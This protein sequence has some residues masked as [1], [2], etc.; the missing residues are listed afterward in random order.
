MSF[1]TS[2]HQS[3]ELFKTTDY[4]II[5]ATKA[6]SPEVG[7]EQLHFRRRNGDVYFK[8]SVENFLKDLGPGKPIYGI[9]GKISLAT[10]DV[11]I[12]VSSVSEPQT[13]LSAQ[14]YN[15]QSFEILPLTPHDLSDPRDRY[16][17]SLIETGLAAC[18]GRLW[19]SYERD[20]TNTVERTFRKEHQG[21]KG[22]HAFWESTEERFF[23]N[24]AM[25]KDFIKHP[26]ANLGRFILPV[27]FG[28]V[29]VKSARVN[30]KPFDFV[31]ISRRSRYRAGTRYFTRGIS[32]EGHAANSN[33][34]EQIVVMGEGKGDE[35]QLFSYVQTRGSV[36]VFWAQ[37]NTLRYQPDLQVMDKPETAAALKAHIDD[38]VEMYGDV[39]LI[40]LVNQKGYEKPVK[41]AFEHAME[42]LGNQKAHY[43]YFDFHT[44]CKGMRFD[45]VQGLVD[46]LKQPLKE[47]GFFQ[48]S[49]KQSP[50]NPVSVQKSIVR[51]NCMDSLDRT[52][53]V[54]S[55]LAK[56]ALTEQLRLAGVLPSAQSI[57]DYED[58]MFLFRNVWADHA[59]TI[60]EPYSGTGALKTDFTRT[61]KRTK[62]G[63]LQDGV[64]SVK[65]YVFN[66]FFDGNRQDAYDL[67]TGSFD[68]RNE[69]NKS[70]LNHLVQEDRSL[71]ERVM[72]YIFFFGLLM[73]LSAVFL[74]RYSK[75][76]ISLFIAQWLPITAF[77][78]LYMLTNG[79]HYVNWPR[80]NPPG[81]ILSWEGPGFRS[82]RKGRG[83]DLWGFKGRVLVDSKPFGVREKKDI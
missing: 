78:L 66:N 67:L 62:A 21:G 5:Q 51:T 19:F 28:T 77:A 58:F 35:F 70:L 29:V 61:G 46:R 80:L 72:P 25:M 33:E 18:R 74:P 30:N 13:L 42:R 54:Q 12:V 48:L 65:R 63:A 73:L 47:Q 44:E 75:A 50:T 55:A 32:P 37:V 39:Y 2:L 40:N 1:S 10:V 52:N 45:R 79:I 26:D 76:P 23:W 41:E 15:A 81:E 38:Q 20:L 7:C 16:L 14:I 64:N 49:A 43:E 57:E 69:E 3:L 68:A 56:H 31:L 4:F 27:I 53:V 11:L 8:N 9:L 24:K 82:V 71:T 6:T 22:E 34:T 36:P 17:Y 83:G 60:S 59:D